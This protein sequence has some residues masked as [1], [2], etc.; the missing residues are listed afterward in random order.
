MSDLAYLSFLA[1]DDFLPGVRVLA[2]SLRKTRPKAPLLVLVTDNVGTATRGE[3]DRL[4][5]A[6]REIERIPFPEG[7]KVS[8]ARWRHN[9][10][11]LRIFEQ[12]QFRKAVYL[13]ADM[14]VCA[15]LDGLFEHPHMSAANAGGM[16]LRNRRW[17]GLNAGLMVIEPDEDLFRRMVSRIGTLDGMGMGDQ[18]FLNSFYPEWP[19]HPELHLDHGYNQFH[20]FLDAY[21]RRFGYR[22]M[23]G[24]V[25]TAAELA[26][27]KLVKVIH[28]ISPDKP[29]LDPEAT[30]RTIRRNR[31]FRPQMARALDLWLRLDEESR[32]P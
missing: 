14:V 26:D 15:N 17:T 28:Y 16:L 8:E 10:S 20:V 4:G 25:P 11:K 13:D 23:E 32:R 31:W 7:M 3:L 27:P 2:H 30:R 29:W 12:V 6:T 5:I 18:G 1:T 19:G 9:Y 24:T 21:R 22:V